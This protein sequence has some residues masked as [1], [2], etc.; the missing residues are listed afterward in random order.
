MTGTTSEHAPVE[1]TIRPSRGWSIVSPRELWRHREL[2]LFFVWRDLKA[3]YAQTSLGAAWALV[4]PLA[5]MATFTLLLQRLGGLPTDGLPAPLFYYAGLVP[6]IYLAQAVNQ[7]ALSLLSNQ[8][9]WTKVHFPRALVP[10]ASVSTPLVDLA[11]ALV[12]MVVLLAW[13]GV[14]PTWRLAALPLVVG[15]AGLVAFAISLWLSAL[16]ARY[17]DVKQIVGFGVQLWLFA[18]PVVYPLTMIPT[19]AR[20][21]YALNPAVPVVEGFRW[22]VLGASALTPPTLAPGLVVAAA[23]LLGGG[24]AFRRLERSL[25]DIV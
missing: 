6:W 14:A 2:C 4:Q 7:G 18:S 11:L 12:P 5:L 9:L 22:A 8:N 1:T 13:Y 20:A 15:L 3:R 19:E 25:V 17:R 21:W 10:L 24:V 16:T 23:L